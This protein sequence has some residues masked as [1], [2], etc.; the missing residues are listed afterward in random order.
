MDLRNP[1]IK[2]G[3]VADRN[4]FIQVRDEIVLR[5]IYRNLLKVKKDRAQVIVTGV[6]D[7]G[8]ME[9]LA[10]NLPVVQFIYA[11]TGLEKKNLFQNAPVISNLSFYKSF[12]DA[13]RRLAGQT[14]LVF[15]N[16]LHRLPDDIG[17][18]KWLQT[19]D[20][21][22]PETLI[23][24]T[25]AAKKRKAGR[26]GGIYKVKMLTHY[27]N[28]AGLQ[29]NSSAYFLAN[30]LPVKPFPGSRLQ[31]ED[32]MKS[33]ILKL[34]KFLLRLDFRISI[35]LNHLNVR[36]RGWYTFAIGKKFT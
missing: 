28:R 23:L 12:E 7:L 21:V 3:P 6:L 14:D 26:R 11:G 19:F 16:N 22:G 5:L 35:L 1:L 27:C 29:I 30:F 36:G 34:A 10:L 13:D 8:L 31:G 15:V 24:V 17:F 18:L 33:L 20:T 32:K 9:F 25:A 2:P 4:I